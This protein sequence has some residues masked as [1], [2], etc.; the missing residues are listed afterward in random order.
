MV[1]GHA[2]PGDVDRLAYSLSRPMVRNHERGRQRFLTGAATSRHTVA[3]CYR[4][5]RP[6]Q[7]VKPIQ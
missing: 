5:S 3:I 1:L 6:R 2:V 4:F 7:L